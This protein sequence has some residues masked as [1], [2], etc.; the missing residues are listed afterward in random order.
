MK[1]QHEAPE[2]L[3]LLSHDLAPLQL[4]DQVRVIAEDWEGRV[5][6]IWSGRDHYAVFSWT[7]CGPIDAGL[8]IYRRDELE[9]IATAG[10]AASEAQR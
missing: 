9:L 2:Q 6:Q 5:A 10:Q 4:R 1:K 7:W 3:S 8:P